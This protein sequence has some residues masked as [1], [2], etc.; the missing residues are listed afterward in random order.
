MVGGVLVGVGVAAV[1]VARMLADGRTVEIT[2]IA[3]DGHANACSR[4][5]GALCRAAAALGYTRATTTTLATESGAS[6][7]AAGFVEVARRAPSEWRRGGEISGR[8]VAD[9]FGN[10]TVPSEVMIRWER[11]LRGSGGDVKR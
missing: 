9:L 2:R 5:Y 1:P 6:P 8:Y 3:T 11:K 10:R 4:I 7:R